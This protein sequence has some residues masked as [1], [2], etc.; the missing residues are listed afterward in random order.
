[1]AFPSRWSP[2]S[3]AAEV[4]RR[5]HVTVGHVLAPRLRSKERVE[6]PFPTASSGEHEVGDGIVLESPDQQPC[7][8]R[9][10]RGR[11]RADG[12]ALRSGSH[13]EIVPPGTFP[14]HGHRSMSIC[15]L[16]GFL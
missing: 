7:Y 11:R 5:V 8:R 15:L 2:Q 1:M 12:G 4:L 9:T 3:D 10:V 14:S 16:L 6:S 13:A